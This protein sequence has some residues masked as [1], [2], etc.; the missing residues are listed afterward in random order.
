MTIG[1]HDVVPIDSFT[2]SGELLVGE[3]AKN[4]AVANPER[5]I[6]SIKRLMG[7]DRRITIGDKTMADS[8]PDPTDLNAS[9]LRIVPNRDP[10]GSGSTPA[11]GNPFTDPAMGAPEVYAWGFRNTFRDIVDPHHAIDEIYSDDVFELEAMKRGIKTASFFTEMGAQANLMRAALLVSGEIKAGEPMPDDYIDQATRWVTMHEVGHTLG[12]RHNFRSSMLGIFL[13]AI[14]YYWPV[15]SPAAVRSSLRP[16]HSM[17]VNKYWL[18]A[19]YEDL[20]VRRLI[21]G[22]LFAASAWFDR[23]VVDGVVN[24]VARSVVSTGRNV[25]RIQTGQV[26][27]Y[28]LVVGIGVPF[29]EPAVLEEVRRALACTGAAAAPAGT[30]HGPGRPDARSRGVGNG[31]RVVPPVGTSTH[32]AQATGRGSFASM[33]ALPTGQ[34]SAI[35]WIAAHG[36]TVSLELHW[37][38]RADSNRHEICPV[39]E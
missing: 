20:I 21:T 8:G 10:D 16:I 13:A 27:A 2:E 9:L 5:T 32:P 26:Q 25:R 18:D 28:A 6:T 14:T 30:A 33:G 3:P 22:G 38:T 29:D 15:I 35:R 39:V 17:L 23:I 24:G 12:L 37:A 36:L 7:T 34:A 11:A 19:V 31:G 4:Q 1:A